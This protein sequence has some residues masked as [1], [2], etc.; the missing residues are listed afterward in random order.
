MQLCVTRIGAQIF[1]KSV[2]RPK[3]LGAKRVTKL[4]IQ[5][6]QA[7][8]ATVRAVI[9]MAPWRSGF[10]RHWYSTEQNTLVC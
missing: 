10:V 4:H 9:A 5:T 6:P 2:S 1:Q 7:F 8:G 3:I